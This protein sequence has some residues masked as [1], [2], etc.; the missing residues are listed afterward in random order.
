MM[1][2]QALLV[3]APIVSLIILVGIAGAYFARKERRQGQ[4]ANSKQN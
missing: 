2:E 1:S 4:H 3:I